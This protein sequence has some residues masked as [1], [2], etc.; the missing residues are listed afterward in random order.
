MRWAALQAIDENS[1]A[2]RGFRAGYIFAGAF[3]IARGVL[4]ALGG[5]PAESLGWLTVGLP[6]TGIGLVGLSSVRKVLAKVS[7]PSA[8]RELH[9][10]WSTHRESVV[11]SLL[12]LIGTVCGIVAVLISLR[13]HPFSMSVLLVLVMSGFTA[14][15]ALFHWLLADSAVRSAL[16]T[17][18]RRS[19]P[20]V[21]L[22]KTMQA[23]QKRHQTL[24]RMLT[25]IG[26]VNEAVDD[27]TQSRRGPRGGR[28]GGASDR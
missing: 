13:S 18:E 2:E 24:P 10:R 12:A 14:G 20:R 5:H 21:A 9:E 1:P 25:T 15:V 16:I 26:V 22:S 11:R 8:P 19:A 6:L 27:C 4:A 7:P 23:I 3:F 28:R 17:G